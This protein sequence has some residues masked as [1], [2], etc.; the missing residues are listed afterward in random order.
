MAHFFLHYITTQFTT[1]SSG[2]KFEAI[3]N[4]SY[5]VSFVLLILANF[6]YQASSLSIERKIN[7]NDHHHHQNNHRPSSGD[8]PTPYVDASVIT[9]SNQVSHY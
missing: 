4:P 3:M 9:E 7:I 6:C 2:F 5:T 8:K 1:N